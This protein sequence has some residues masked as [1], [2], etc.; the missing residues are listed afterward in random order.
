VKVSKIKQ[1]LIA[2]AS[3]AVLLIT[4]APAFAATAGCG[5]GCD[6]LDP[7]NASMEDANGALRLCH[8]SARTL[9]TRNVPGLGSVD[10]RY[11]S[12]CRIA[13]ARGAGGVE[14]QVRS[15]WHQ[16]DSWGAARR[17]EI[18]YDTDNGG[19]TRTVND[20]NLYAQA[21]SADTSGN[22]YCTPRA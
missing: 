2:V 13:W 7:N 8:T 10:L 16:S 1:A 21:C 17:I 12:Y 18:Q 5:F 3:A 22:W 15:Y 19:Y 6:G 4:P 20:A 9:S 11:S 14:I